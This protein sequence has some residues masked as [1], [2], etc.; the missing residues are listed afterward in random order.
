MSE[1][2]RKFIVYA[3]LVLAVIWG[4]WN[5]PLS[6]GKKKLCDDPR[7][8]SCSDHAMSQPAASRSP[9]T[10]NLP[11]LDSWENDPFVRVKTSAKRARKVRQ[12]QDWNFKLSAISSNGYGSMAIID[13]QIVSE[14]GTIDDW[15]VAE[16]DDNSVVLTKSSNKIELTLKRR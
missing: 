13:G 5:N 15:T 6:D 11:D 14:R 10:A 8:V 4:I 1:K 7:S 9:V 3:I 2:K 16:I 12:D